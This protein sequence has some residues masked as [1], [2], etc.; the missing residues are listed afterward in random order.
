MFIDD[1][2]ARRLK[3][4][5]IKAVSISL[6]SSTPE[7]H[8]EFRGVK[9]S[10]ERAIRAMKALKNNNILL[11]DNTTVTKQDYDEIDD[12]MTLAEELGAENFHL[13]FLV[14]TGRG[15]KIDDISPIMYENMIKGIFPKIA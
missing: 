8:D 13:F 11:Q 2:I 3:E 12:I 7:G 6:D 14:P 4:A 15:A 1:R 10:W 9:G 5:E